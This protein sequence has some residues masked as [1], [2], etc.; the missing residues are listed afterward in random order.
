MVFQE[1]DTM[2]RETQSNAHSEEVSDSTLKP[3]SGGVL[4]KGAD[5]SDSLVRALLDSAPEG[6]LL[7]DNQI[8]AWLGI[9]KGTQ[10][11]QRKHQSGWLWRCTVYVGPRT[12]R[13]LKSKVI[14]IIPELIGK[15]WVK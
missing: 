9:P 11:S 15:A 14:A 4:S 10:A 3:D 5:N 12:P 7:S 8:E 2:A 1:G 6:E 13:V